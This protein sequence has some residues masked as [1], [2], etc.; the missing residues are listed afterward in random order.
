[1][2]GNLPMLYPIL[3]KGALCFAL[4][5][6]PSLLCCISKVFEK[7]IFDHICAYLKYHG[8]LSKKK[9]SGFMQVDSTINQLISICNLLY[10]GLDNGDEL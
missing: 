7:I 9:Q 2:L 5:I 10:K 3:K 1:M 4:T 6:A 8:I